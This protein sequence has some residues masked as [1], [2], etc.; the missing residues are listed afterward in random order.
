MASS[1]LE[2]FE[3]ANGIPV[4]VSEFVMIVAIEFS[5]NPSTKKVILE[6]RKEVLW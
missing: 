5:P 2:K 4:F 1:D 3:D 6:F